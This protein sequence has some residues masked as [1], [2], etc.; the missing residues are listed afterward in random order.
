VKVTV[1]LG[2]PGSG[3]AIYTVDGISY[4]VM[5]PYYLGSMAFALLSI[6]EKPGGGDLVRNAIEDYYEC[7]RG[8]RPWPE[9]FARDN[10]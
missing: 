1:D 3:M 9:W 8:E 7:C 10:E 5:D 2:V 4:P 6:I